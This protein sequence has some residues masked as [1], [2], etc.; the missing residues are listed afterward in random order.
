MIDSRVS[1]ILGR[2]RES[3]TDMARGARLSYAA[4]HAL[5]HGTSKMI[6]F[7]TLDKLCRYFDLQPGDLFMYVPD[8]DR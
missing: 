4:A 7:E 6:T 2:R 3:I 1:E 8:G 5:Y